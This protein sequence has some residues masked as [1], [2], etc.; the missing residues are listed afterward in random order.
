LNPGTPASSIDAVLTMVDLV[1]VMSVNPGFSGQAFIPDV[2]PK[3]KAIRKKLDKVNPWALIEMDGGL[4]PETLPSAI[5]AGVQVAV[6]A[7]AVF[8]HPDGIPA[9]IRSLQACFPK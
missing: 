3:V 9:G 8:K 6:A 7:Y 2:L 4:T 5:Q 1:L